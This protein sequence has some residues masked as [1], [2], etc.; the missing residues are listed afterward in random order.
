M[1]PYCKQCVN[2]TF[3]P[4]ASVLQLTSDTSHLGSHFTGVRAQSHRLL[5]LQTPAE[6][7]RAPPFLP[8]W[9]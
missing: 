1:C 6:G 5:L 4:Q 9:L 7:L 8:E 2:V 3:P